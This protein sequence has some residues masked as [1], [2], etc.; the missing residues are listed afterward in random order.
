[1]TPEDAVGVNTKFANDSIVLITN[2]MRS[3]GEYKQT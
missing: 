3:D 2:E 1:L